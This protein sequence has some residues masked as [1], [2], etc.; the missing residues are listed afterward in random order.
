MTSVKA[1]HLAKASG[2]FLKGKW[3][4]EIDRREVSVLAVAGIWAMVRRPTCFP[5]VCHIEQLETVAGLKFDPSAYV[6]KPRSKAPR[7]S[8]KAK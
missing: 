6:G 3:S 5:Y 8:R 1:I 7:A 2:T 4:F